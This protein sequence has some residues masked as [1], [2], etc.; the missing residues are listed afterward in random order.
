MQKVNRIVDKCA[1]EYY[2]VSLSSFL[3]VAPASVG[4]LHFILIGL[5][6]DYFVF[7]PVDV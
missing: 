6:R 7:A 1:D 2:D 5:A 3:A 4:Y